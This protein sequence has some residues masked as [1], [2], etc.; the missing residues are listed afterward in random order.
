MSQNTAFLTAGVPYRDRTLAYAGPCEELHFMYGICIKTQFLEARSDDMVQE[1]M[2]FMR[3]RQ[4]DC[5]FQAS[6]G[7]ST[8]SKL[9]L[10]S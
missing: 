2:L 6:L 3:L 10:V 9:A 8:S 7:Y 5:K 1:S 4:E